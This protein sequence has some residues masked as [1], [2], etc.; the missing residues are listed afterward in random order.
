MPE[1]P[2]PPSESSSPP[3]AEPPVEVA[4]DPYAALRHADCR[5]FLGGRVISVFGEQMLL[6][7][8]VGYELYRLTNSKVALGL[9]GLVLVVPVIGLALPAGHV[10]DQYSRRRVVTTCQVFAAAMAFLLAWVA[11]DGLGDGPHA[12]LAVLG[13]AAARLSAAFGEERTDFSRPAVPATYLLLL[14]FATVR[15]FSNAARGAMLAQTVPL[16]A[17]PNA[18]GWNNTGFQLAAVTGPAVG[19]LALAHFG[20]PALCAATGVCSAIFAVMVSRVKGEA[21]PRKREPLSLSSMA[22]GARFLVSTRLLLATVTLDL[23]A[24]L[25]GGATA[26]LPVFAERL[27]CGPTGLGLLQASPALGA[28]AM[29]VVQSHRPPMRRAGVALLWAVAGFGAATIVFGLSDSFALSAAMLFLTG[30]FDNIS[31]VV[32]DTLVQVLTP[33]ELRGRV[34]AVNNVFIGASNQLGALESGLTAAA[35]GPVLSVVGGGF[36]T[37][38]VVLLT[39]WIWPE[40]ARLKRLDGLTKAG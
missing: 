39:A 8:G 35:F 36:G 4:H 12:T 18:V 31:V 7:C 30:A 20:F 34:A 9:V 11:A 15:T 38:A 1:P 5:F 24:V 17:F 13:D 2:N 33:D 37:I 23:F 16:S 10:A 22:A 25:L 27:G 14:G 29:A 19:G 32:R 6:N 26:L 28:A 40:V 21:P 3:S